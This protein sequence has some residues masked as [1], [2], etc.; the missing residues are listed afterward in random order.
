MNRNRRDDDPQ[1][2]GPSQDQVRPPEEVSDNQPGSKG[3]GS[4]H[5]AGAGMA[6]G[7]DDDLNAGEFVKSASQRPNPN[8]PSDDAIMPPGGD[9][10][11]KR[12]TM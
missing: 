1:S 5:R 6:A 10:G 2:E 7:E 9:L 8:Q 3:D 11:K 12:N 4:A